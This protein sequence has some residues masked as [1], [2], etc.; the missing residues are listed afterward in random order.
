MSADRIV[1]E[2]LESVRKVEEE[3]NI[4]GAIVVAEGRPSCTDCMRIEVDSVKDFMKVLAAMVR[5]GIAMGSLPVLVM[6]RRTSN[7]VAVYGVDM[8]NQVILSLEL[9]LRY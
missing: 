3:L 1:D 9:E 4:S 5:Q 2:V 6:I 8:C 7:S